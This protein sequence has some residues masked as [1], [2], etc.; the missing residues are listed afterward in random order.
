MSASNSASEGLGN[1]ANFEQVSDVTAVALSVPVCATGD[2]ARLLTLH[3]TA[4]MPT[5][6]AI[7]SIR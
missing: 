4:Y 6:R 3:T 1:Q 2:D 7:P 5:A